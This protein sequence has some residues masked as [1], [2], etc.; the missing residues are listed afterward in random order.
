VSALVNDV[1]GGKW[2]SPVTALSAAACA[3]SCA[4]QDPRPGIGRCTADHPRWSTASFAA[5]GPFTLHAAYAQARHS[6]CGNQRLESRVRENRMHGSEGGEGH[7]LPDPIDVV[8]TGV[9][10]TMEGNL[11]C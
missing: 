9:V 7:T 1:K 10:L 11:E 2:Y 5:H 8:R 4:K 6:R 3:P